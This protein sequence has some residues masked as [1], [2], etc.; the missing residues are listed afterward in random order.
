MEK[1]SEA[2][3]KLSHIYELLHVFSNLLKP[4]RGYIE[5][6]CALVLVVKRPVQNI[7]CAGTKLLF[8]WKL[9]NETIISHNVC[10]F[11]K[12]L[13]KCGSLLIPLLVL[14]E[15]VCALQRNF[16]TLSNQTAQAIQKSCPIYSTPTLSRWY[17]N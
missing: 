4:G 12:I 1:L 10:L 13:R 16:L 6:W 9:I 17:N 7:K 5:L 14:K 2:K 11:E 3:Q 8:Y 15:N